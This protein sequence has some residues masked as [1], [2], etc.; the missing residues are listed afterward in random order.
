MARS[1]LAYDFTDLYR[2]SGPAR[3]PRGS[4]WLPAMSLY[5]P[6]VLTVS[7]LMSAKYKDIN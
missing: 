4:L 1:P 3:I 2:S 5:F 7:V 6:G